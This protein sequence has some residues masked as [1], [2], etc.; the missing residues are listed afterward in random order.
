MTAIELNKKWINLGPA[1]NGGF[2]SSKIAADCLCDLFIGVDIEQ[3]RCLILSIENSARITMADEIK[4]HIGIR[5]YD[6]SGHIVITL[7]HKEF[8][9]LFNELILSLYGRLKTIRNNKTA[10]KQMLDGFR[11]WCEFFSNT[12]GGRL[13]KEEVQGLFGELFYLRNLLLNCLPTQTNDILRSWTGPS[14][15]GQDFIFPNRNIEVKTKDSSSNEVN[16]SSEFQ[17]Q[18]EL[19]KNLELHVLSVESYSGKGQSLKE[20]WNDV[21][22]EVNNKQGDLAIIIKAISKKVIID[23]LDLYDQWR[24]NPSSEV[25]YDCCNSEFPKI[26][27]NNIAKQIKKVKYTLRLTGVES[28]IIN[29]KEY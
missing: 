12:S 19:G 26:A 10:A 14:D 28:Y 23:K 15:K 21:K 8:E 20:I 24:F 13:S 17:L 6:N 29:S 16:I 18:E 27:S 1:R 9:V 25:T 2:E 5:Y 11:T 22:T 3:N 4:D 7:F